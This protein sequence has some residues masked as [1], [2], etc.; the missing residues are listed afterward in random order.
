ME[1]DILDFVSEAINESY[2]EENKEKELYTDH[3]LKEILVDERVLYLQGIALVMN[4]DKEIH[5][6]EVKYLSILLNS[7]ELEASS[8]DELLTFAKSP[9]KD[10]IKQ[11]F[12]TFK[13]KCIAETFIYDAM[14]MTQRDDE[15]QD[16]ETKLEAIFVNQLQISSNKYQHIQYLF[17]AISVKNWHACAMVFHLNLLDLEHYLHIFSFHKAD[18]NFHI[19]K[20][21]SITVND[22]E[23]S[24]VPIP[25]GTFNMG[26]Y[27]GDKNAKPVHSVNL[28]AFSMME[29]VVTFDLM[30]E[31]L[32]DTGASYLPR[33]TYGQGRGKQ[34]LVDISWDDITEN[35]IPWLNEKTGREFRLP[36]ESE[37]EYS[38]R[39]GSISAFNTG[40]IINLE[41]ANFKTGQFEVNNVQE[42]KN[43][44]PN[45]WGLYDMHGNVLE[46]VQDSYS[47]NYENHSE[48][49]EP[50]DS[51]ETNEKILRGG[52]ADSWRVSE[53]SS[54]YRSLNDKYL[55]SSTIGF[56]LVES[57]PS[58]TE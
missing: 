35:F 37:W 31:R 36:S 29:C 12:S 52:G 53:V 24:L 13:N 46:W 21:K 25:L 23:F 27:D 44:E 54:H 50:F 51:L 9:D 30:D 38:C 6:D 45:G 8:L 2:N 39:A 34:P 17:K 11:L 58:L 57:L 41:Q 42:V 19:D 1:L 15:L 3:P 40:D 10:A 49:A 33:E 28:K 32:K 18:I 22:T 14:V 4:A 16:V 20:V 56:R 5:D 48:E 55:R 7:C 43:Y 26:A 47:E